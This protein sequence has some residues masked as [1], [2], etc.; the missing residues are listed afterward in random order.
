MRYKIA[1]DVG[2]IE[3]HYVF[4][5][6]PWR[7][8]PGLKDKVLSDAIKNA[9]MQIVD[10]LNERLPEKKSQFYYPEIVNTIRQAAVVVVVCIPEET[11]NVSP[12][13]LY[14]LGFAHSIGKPTVI[15]TTPG[16]ELPVKVSDLAG[17][18]FF[19]MNENETDEDQKS[20]LTDVIKIAK[21]NGSPEWII[22]RKT[23][24]DSGINLIS[25]GE[26]NTIKRLFQVS[27]KIEL[28][29]TQLRNG[30]IAKF[31][32]LQS[33][34]NESSPERDTQRFAQALNELKKE[35]QEFEIYHD[36]IMKQAIFEYQNELN[37]I[38]QSKDK[39]DDSFTVTYIKEQLL[40]FK[41]ECE[42]L[43]DSI[44]P[45]RHNFE[46]PEFQ[47]KVRVIL[48]NSLWS[49]IL[50]IGCIVKNCDSLKQKCFQILLYR[51]LED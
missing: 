22:D 34:L 49:L 14:E 33:Q 36:S 1:I 32:R 42:N 43:S 16:F 4:V 41:N 7:D 2:Q 26:E 21:A 10:R 44:N 40:K 17:R 47:Q 48:S 38:E 50:L 46:E 18:E 15:I 31:E 39:K 37:A 28:S 35:L 23:Y 8:I 51:L 29:F 45:I 6:R 11:G 25:Y 13:V 12:N 20:K 9:D 24:K 3:K 19:F 5:V 30:S 27:C